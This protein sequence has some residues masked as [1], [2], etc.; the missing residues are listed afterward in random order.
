M[1]RA[2][3]ATVIV[4]VAAALPSGFAAAHASLVDARP[5][6]R[7]VVTRPPARVVLVFGEA[8]EPAF[9]TLGVFS[10][11]GARVDT[12]D[13]EA[14][15]ANGRELSVGLP[16]DLP[17]GH[18]TVRYRVLSTDGHVVEGSYRFTLAPPP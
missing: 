10:A 6:R 9:S 17:A 7:A 16:G 1:R 14:L 18:Y 3:A 8:V 11:S 2:L 12:G 15:P 5:G 4:L 13:V